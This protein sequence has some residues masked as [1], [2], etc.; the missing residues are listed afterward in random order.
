MEYWVSM[1]VPFRQELNIPSF[2]HSIIPK[3][4]AHSAMRFEFQSE[5]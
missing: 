2:H 5:V 1:D 4:M 3:G